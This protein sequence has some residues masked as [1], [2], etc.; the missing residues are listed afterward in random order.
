MGCPTSSI[1]VFSQGRIYAFVSRHLAFCLFF[2]PVPGSLTSANSRPALPFKVT[3]AYPRKLL[4]PHVRHRTQVRP[5]PQYPVSHYI[6]INYTLKISCDPSLI[7]ENTSLIDGSKGGLI[8]KWEV[9]LAVSKLG[10]V[11]GYAL[12]YLALPCPSLGGSPSSAG[13]NENSMHLETLRN[14]AGRGGAVGEGKGGK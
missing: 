5:V 8:L 3:A 2:L 14:T 6:H 12:T 10:A 9:F 7:N 1:P 4:E 13:E 11:C